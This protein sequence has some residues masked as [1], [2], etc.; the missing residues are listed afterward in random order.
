MEIEST[1]NLCLLLTGV[2]LALSLGNRRK[3][4]KR[5]LNQL[6]QITLEILITFLQ[7]Q[8]SLKPEA[9]QGLIPLIEN[10]KGRGS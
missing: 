7:K 4:M 6:V 3:D 2:K 1:E 5:H 8:Y 10:L 9:K